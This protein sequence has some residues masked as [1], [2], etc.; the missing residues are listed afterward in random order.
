MLSVKGLALTSGIAM[1]ACVLIIGLSN[2]VWP[3]YG[4]ALLEILESIYP[5]YTNTGGF[6]S[7]IVATLYAAVDWTI[8]GAIVAWLY[9]KLRDCCS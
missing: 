6:G 1:G 5:G 9:N 3:P 8:A 7:V 4:A 2:M